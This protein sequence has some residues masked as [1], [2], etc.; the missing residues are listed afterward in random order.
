MK[1]REWCRGSIAAIATLGAVAACE[2]RVVPSQ[3]PADTRVNSDSVLAVEFLVDTMRVFLI[4]SLGRSRRELWVK[5]PSGAL[6]EAITRREILSSA[7][8]KRLRLN[9]VRDMTR[10]ARELERKADS[11]TGGVTPE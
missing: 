6:V 7:Q 11:L 10:E 5:D 4:D 8:T 9:E 3:W 1:S 2:R